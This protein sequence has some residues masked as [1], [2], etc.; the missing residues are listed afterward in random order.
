MVAHRKTK[1]DKPLRGADIRVIQSSIARMPA[2]VTGGKALPQRR[3]R[4]LVAVP[5]KKMPKLMPET[6]EQTRERLLDDRASGE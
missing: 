1:P 2:E 4:L 5:R 3:G 6:V